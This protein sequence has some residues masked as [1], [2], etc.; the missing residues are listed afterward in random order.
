MTAR[1]A[2][3]IATA[4]ATIAAAVLAS[5]ASAAVERPRGV[6]ES[7]RTSPGWGHLTDYTARSSLVVGPLAVRRAGVML[8][9]ASQVGGNKLFVSVRGGHSV[10]VELPP[11]TRVGA[12]LGFGK[13]ESANVELRDSRRVVRFVACERGE[14]PAPWDGWPV[15][16]WVGFLLAA[17]PRCVPLRIWVDD[18]PTP[19]RSLIRFGVR[20]CDGG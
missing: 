9:Y 1:R 6:V 15:T 10:T 11:D 3:W 4:A 5:T 7:C 18:E 12:G 2:T 8:G 14:R 17:S 13:F 19:R 20:S 16:S